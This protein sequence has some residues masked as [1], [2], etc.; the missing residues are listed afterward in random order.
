MVQWLRLQAST[1]GGESLIPDQ[2]TK[3]SHTT[4][5]GQKVKIN[6]CYHQEGLTLVM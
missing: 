2:G 5:H 4:W 3:I 1:T 6:Y